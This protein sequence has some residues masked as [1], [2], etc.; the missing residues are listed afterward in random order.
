MH[1]VTKMCDQW[2]FA[3]GS[4][5]SRQQKSDRTGP[6]RE[7]RLVSLMGYRIAFNKRGKDR[8]GKANIVPDANDSV[9]GI[10]YRC[11]PTALDEMDVREGVPHGHYRRES[12]C[13]CSES[14]DELQAIAY[15]AGDSFIDDS[16][17]PDE[18]YLEI[19]LQGAREHRLPED[20][21]LKIIRAATRGDWRK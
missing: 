17:R 12:V 9:W 19:I 2:Y 8:R 5:L 14:G 10:V 15:I 21:I 3:Y 20:Y 13:V 16:L 6:I 18:C 1:E 4:N 7:E 11:S